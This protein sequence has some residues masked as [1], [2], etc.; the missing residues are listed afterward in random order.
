MERAAVTSSKATPAGV[1]WP[2]RSTL[3]LGALPSAPGCARLHARNVMCEW[4]LTTLADNVE[5]VV[6]ELATNAVL[7]S[8]HPDGQPRYEDGAGLPRVHL[9]LSSDRTRVL[10]EVWDQNLGLPTPKTAGPDDES[11]R[12]LLLIEALCDRWDWDV[13]PGWNGKLVWA[14]MRAEPAP[15][16]E[17]PVTGERRCTEAHE[18]AGGGAQ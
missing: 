8:T 18:R 9:R 7:A 14:E 11:G 3:V 4:G 16:H 2:L 12:G 10:I 1:T 17:T 5:L 15:S 6:S 13:P